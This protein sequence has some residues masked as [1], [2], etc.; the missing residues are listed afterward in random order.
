VVYLINYLQ[1]LPGGARFLPP[2]NS[3]GKSWA[4]KFA[5]ESD[6][7]FRLVDAVVGDTVLETLE[8]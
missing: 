5:A 4:L 7:Q 2:S 1:G 6:G 8:T 3:R